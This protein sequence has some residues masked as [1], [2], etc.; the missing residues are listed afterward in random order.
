MYSQHSNTDK[1]FTLIWHIASANCLYM[2]FVPFYQIFSRFL[3]FS[4]GIPVFCSIPVFGL[5]G[6]FSLTF[7]LLYLVGFSLNTPG[8]ASFSLSPDYR[9]SFLSDSVEIIRNKSYLCNMLCFQCVPFCTDHMTKNCEC[10][11][12]KA[13]SYLHR[14]LN[15]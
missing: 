9:S 3:I 1:T 13:S 2:F 4:L 10:S 6:G 12:N 11:V 15:A 5:F 8:T 14:Q 7:P